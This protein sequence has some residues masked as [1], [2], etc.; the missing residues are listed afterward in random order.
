[1]TKY[2]LIIDGA[3]DTTAFQP[4][5]GFVEVP[6]VVFGGFTA[7]PDGTFT[8]PVPPPVPFDD[9]TPKEFWR[10]ALSIGITEDSI[11][12]D[13]DAIP[14]LVAE[15]KEDLKIAVGKATSF[16][17]TDPDLIFM[18]DYKGFAPEQ[19]DTLWLWVLAQREVEVLV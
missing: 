7:N 9:L 10:G 17:R 15:Q 4:E 1:M 11:K 2:A 6:D 16:S 19:I 13:I 14:D 3:V 5:D 18:L 12:A 8:A